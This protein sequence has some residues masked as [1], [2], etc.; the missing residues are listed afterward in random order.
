M[1]NPWDQERTWN[2]KGASTPPSGGAGLLWLVAIIIAVV[3]LALMAKHGANHVVF[4]PIGISFFFMVMFLVSHR[5]EAR[6][7]AWKREVARM[8]DMHA[9][10]VVQ[11]PRPAAPDTTMRKVFDRFD[12]KVIS[13]GRDKYWNPQRIASFLDYA[14][15]Y[16]DTQHASALLAANERGEL[17]RHLDAALQ[18]ALLQHDIENKNESMEPPF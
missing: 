15:D 12:A 8:Q 9:Q 10:Q 11:A 17:D 5:R 18:R 4:V 1:M 16:V 2:E 6:R 3:G 7:L 14:R 13:H